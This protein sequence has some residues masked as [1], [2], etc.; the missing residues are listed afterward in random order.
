MEVKL[1]HDSKAALKLLTITVNDLID[2]I[3]SLHGSIEKNTAALNEVYEGG[4]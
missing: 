4:E 2:A 3:V 1:D